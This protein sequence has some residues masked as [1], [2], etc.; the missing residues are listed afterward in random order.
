MLTV[1]EEFAGQLMKCPLC[2]GTFTVPALPGAGNPEPDIYSV[3]PEPA[4]PHPPPPSSFQPAPTSP[5]APPSTATTA[6]P[7][8]S[9]PSTSTLPPE[10]YQHAVTIW[11]SPRV[12]PWVAPAC[13]LLVLILSL[14]PWV[15]LYP[16]G[17]AAA[18]QTPWQATFGW[19]SVDGDMKTAVPWQTADKEKDKER[20][21]YRPGVSVLT[22]FY[23]LLFFPVL[24]LTVASVVLDL[25]HL[26]LPPAVQ[27]LLPWRWG[28]V[29]AVNLI[30]F[31]F[32]ALQLLLNFS[33]ES[34]FKEYVEKEV[35]VPD[36]EP[37]TTQQQKA[38]EALQGMNLQALHRTVALRLVV[39]LHLAAIACAALMFWVAR[40]GPGRPLPKVELVW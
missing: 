8:P 29:A 4:P 33:L 36:K 12:L 38:E 37:K 26:K 24:A 18:T 6:T 1:P 22:I 23:L 9:A 39:L 34:R 10:G 15:G 17:V 30:L 40:R 2:G 31:L 27:Q 25:L 11:F 20:D 35:K 28:I 3:R 7:P 32:L 14:F 16:G 5:A 19:V 21:K 13:L